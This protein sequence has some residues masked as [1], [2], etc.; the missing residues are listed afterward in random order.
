MK[1]IITI[2]LSH[3]IVMLK[4][5]GDT[6]R[7]DPHASRRID[8]LLVDEWKRKPILLK[9]I[10]GFSIYLNPN[11]FGISPAIGVI[12]W[13][14]PSVTELFKK[15]LKRGS[16]VVDV[17]A[18]IGWYTLMAAQRIG[19]DGS[20]Y[21]FEPEPVNFAFLT[22]SIKTNRY[23]NVDANEICI[24]NIEGQLPF[25]LALTNLGSHSII[26]QPDRPRNVYVKCTTLDKA[27]INLDS[28]DILKIDVEGSEPEVLEG[29]AQTVTKTR[30]IIM[31]W[32]PTS[33]QT[34]DRKQ[35]LSNLWSQFDVYVCTRSPF[36][37]RRLSFDELV[38]L[39]KQ[40]NI[41]LR[42]CQRPIRSS[43]NGFD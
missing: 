11:D 4:T 19:D 31:E 21:A 8:E 34:K 6:L 14:E 23:S 30:H 15:L 43:C 37:V 35:M 42:R 28:I 22:R 25:H 41:Y 29:A 40:A 12:G 3:P 2:F 24:S 9:H 20:V 38:C 32:N 16:V 13:Y 36:L 39:R 10:Y 18:N 33:W 26:P 1:R 7:D 5:F 17:G 27:L